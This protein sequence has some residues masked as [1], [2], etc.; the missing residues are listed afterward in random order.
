MSPY[1]Q[2]AVQ[3]LRYTVTGI[4]DS[5]G[6]Q[7]VKATGLSGQTIGQMVRSQHFGLSSVPPAGSEGLALPLGGR[8][9]RLWALGSEHPG[10][11]PKGTPMGGTVL[12][13][14]YGDA[15]SI[16]QANLRVVHAT[17]ITLQA[18]EIELIG[19]VT[20]GGAAGSGVPCSKQGTVD[21]NGDV[22]VSNLAT[23][24]NVV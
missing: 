7:F 20:L 17:K 11:R 24:V 14:A 19:N 2:S 13:D 22:D 23:K 10:L 21:S 16:V 6:Q 9:D 15:V 1:D 18:P 4:D 5:G 8:A 12:Y 3:F